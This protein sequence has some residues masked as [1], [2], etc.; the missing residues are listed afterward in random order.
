MSTVD[1]L[2]AARDL[3]SNPARWTH[4]VIARDADDRPVYYPLDP[5]AC[6]WCAV[7]AVRCAVGV[8][9]ERLDHAIMALTAHLDENDTLSIASFNDTHGHAAVLDLFDRTI[10]DLERDERKE[11][12][13]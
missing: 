10:A 3:I 5:A 9:D 11:Q 4:G 2:R 1:D 7:G 6:S 8:S 13:T 12:S